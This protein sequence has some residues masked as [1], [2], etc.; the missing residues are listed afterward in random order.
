M[1]IDYQLAWP[2]PHVASEEAVVL[3]TDRKSLVLKQPVATSGLVRVLANG[4]TFIPQA[5]LYSTATL[6]STTSGP[7]DFEPLKDTIT[8]KTSLGS[9]THTLGVST[10]QRFTTAALI[11]ALLRAGFDKALLS[12]SKGHLC[13]S[14]TNAV[15][16]GSFVEVS[17]TAKSAL[18]FGEG[19]QSRARGQKVFPGWRLVSAVGQTS[20]FPQFTEQL[21]GNPAFRVTYSMPVHNCLRCGGTFVEND[22]RHDASGQSIMVANEDLLYQATLKI[23]LTDLGS[24]PYY[25]WYGTS[26]KERIGSKALS[27]VAATLSEDVRKALSKFQDLQTQQGEI[28]QVTPK[29]RLYAIL[30]IQVRP[31]ER[32]PT[33]FLLDV[34]VQN[35]SGEPVNISIVYSVPDVVSV[36]SAGL[37]LGLQ[38]SGLTLE[39]A[40]NLLR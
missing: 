29:E 26:I 13:I 19:R 34:T 22:F 37:A 35:A 2:C 20:R 10:V 21:R 24:N 8:I 32:D 17:G 39:Q 30:D 33:V 14:D 36:T 31:H 6:Y 9:F 11:K 27:N 16:Q 38:Q 4:N 12:E 1:S 25:P 18:G 15:G 23:L 5:G 3:G 40:Q 7:F 28:Q